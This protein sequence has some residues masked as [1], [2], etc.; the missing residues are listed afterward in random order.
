MTH[1]GIVNTAVNSLIHYSQFSKHPKL[2]RG[3]GSPATGPKHQETERGF[4]QNGHGGE[5]G[6]A[7]RENRKRDRESPHI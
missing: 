3:H 7:F 1:E 6:K 4:H 5:K 2:A